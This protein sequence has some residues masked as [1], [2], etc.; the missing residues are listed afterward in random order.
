M[1]SYWAVLSRAMLSQKYYWNHHMSFIR[2]QPPSKGRF[3]MIKSIVYHLK[4]CRHQR[5]CPSG[6]TSCLN[7]LSLLK[8][9]YQI[10]ILC[11]PLPFPPCVLERVMGTWFAR[12]AL[13]AS[14]DRALACTESD[15]VFRVIDEKVKYTDH[16]N[17][18]ENNHMLS[19][20]LVWMPP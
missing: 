13:P 18:E 14:V 12:Q 3:P 1:V 11:L 15:T 9:C 4:P 16:K 8:Q 17:Y 19:S 20:K 10:I 6:S 7:F 5:A 2:W